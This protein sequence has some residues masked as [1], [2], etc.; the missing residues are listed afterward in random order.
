VISARTARELRL[1]RST[2][3]LAL[4]V[5]GWV[6]IGYLVLYWLDLVA[7]LGANHYDAWT[8]WATDPLNPYRNSLLGARGAY[9]YSPAWVQLMEPLR[10]LPF[11]VVYACWTAIYLL[12]LGWLVGPL[13]AAAALVLMTTARLNIAGGNVQLMTGIVLVIAMRYPAAWSYL[14]LTKITPGVA[15][16]WFAL[17][18]EWRSL[19]IA[20]GVTAAIAAASFVVAPQLWVEWLRTLGSNA[21]V[22]VAAPILRVPLLPRL[23]VSAAIVAWGAWRNRPAA[24]ILAVVLAQPV[25]WAGAITMLLAAFRLTGWRPRWPWA[26]LMPPPATE[27]APG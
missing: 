23:A 15:L 19:V 13:G 20:I 10:H 14:L 12:A 18:R 26:S 7:H 4:D 21:S 1:S 9:L 2:A 6:A 3:T 25:V 27:P 22:E 8:Y 5:L 16:L 24:L 17:R 11:P